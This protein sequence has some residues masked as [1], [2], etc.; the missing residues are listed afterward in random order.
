MNM[1]IVYGVLVCCAMLVCASAPSSRATEITPDKSWRAVTFDG[2]KV[3]HAWTSR[4]AHGD[5]VETADVMVLRVRQGASEG[6]L[7]VTQRHRERDDGTPLSFSSEMHAGHAITRV[8]GEI[9][10]GVATVTVE[11]DGDMQSRRIA[12]P[13]AIHF[14]DAQQRLLRESGVAI[15]DVVRFNTLDIVDLV[16]LAAEIEVRSRDADGTRTLE[17]RMRGKVARDPGIV[18]IDRDGR[19]RAIEERVAGLPLR[20]QACDRACALAPDRAL[21]MLD[22]L[23]VRSPFHISP[24]ALKHRLRFVLARPDGDALRLPTIGEQRSAEESQGT[25]VH[26]CATCG[27]EAAP[28]AATLRRARAPSLWLQSDAPELRSMARRAVGSAPDDDRRMQRLVTFVRAH[29]RGRT[30]VSGY[31]TALHA[32]R[33]RRGD[34]S[35][36][37]M[38]LAALGRTLDIPTRLVAGLAYAETQ[39]GRRAVFAPHLWVQAWIDGRWRSYDAALASFDYGHIAFALSYGDPAELDDGMLQTANLRIVTAGMVRDGGQSNPVVSASD[40]STATVRG[41]SSSTGSETAIR[42]RDR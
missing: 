32:A 6:E 1:R 14:P 31:A 18:T 24:L 2:I 29:M 39:R 30:D 10:D 40:S 37:A 27:E 36:F 7:R 28:D 20:Q 9:V 19:V 15:G 17:Q 33:T 13:D 3:G 11:V 41:Q 12:L 22:Q 26:I 4:A 38:L 25:V 5:I 8:R 21:D 42:A 35:E 16:P 23:T 34:C